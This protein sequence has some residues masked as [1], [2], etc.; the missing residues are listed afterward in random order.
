MPQTGVR[1][2]KLVEVGNQIMLGLQIMGFMNRVEENST[3]Q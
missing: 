2:V 3:V 1:N